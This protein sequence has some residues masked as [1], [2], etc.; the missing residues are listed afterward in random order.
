MISDILQSGNSPHTQTFCYFFHKDNIYF[1]RYNAT[2]RTWSFQLDE[3]DKLVKEMSKYKE[4][5]QK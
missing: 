3:H 5:C 2:T 4:G 1:R